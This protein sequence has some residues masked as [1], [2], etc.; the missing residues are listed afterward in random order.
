MNLRRKT[1]PDS[2]YL[3]LDTLCNAFGGIILLAVLVVLLTSKEKTQSSKAADSREMMQ[4]RLAI[5]Q[6]DLQ[7]SQQLAAS[8]RAKAND[9][10]VKQQ[11]ALLSTRKDL[12]D[13]IQQTR[14]TVA[15]NSKDLDTASAVDPSERLKFLNAQLAAAEAHKLEAK[16]SL[17]AADENTKRLK[18]R[19]ADLERQVTA[20]LDELQRP[21]RLPKEHETGK[22]VI[23][24]IAR[25]GHIYLC[26]NF[27]LSRN[28]TDIDWTTTLTGETAEPRRGQGIDPTGS[29]AGLI[30]FFKNMSDDSVYVAFCVYEDS[31]P[32]F[33]RAKQL[34]ADCGLAYGWEPFQISD[35]PVSFG[36]VGHTPKPQ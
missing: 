32:A 14:E 16:N 36:A 2:L 25:Y 18:Q 19:L 22:R 17:A 34:A 5:A 13:A 28:E 27:D 21:L 15:Q 30:N 7:K 20:K 4:R 12:Q 8:L 29:T 26:R 9:E 24:I 33:I 23:Y 6:T 1:P 3:L 35:G 10:R 31:F 11:V